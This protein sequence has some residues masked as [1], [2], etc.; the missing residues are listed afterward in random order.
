MV[1]IKKI[2]FLKNTPTNHELHVIIP[3][4]SLGQALPSGILCSHP[5]LPRDHHLSGY[6]NQYNRQ[7]PWFL[8]GL[9]SQMVGSHTQ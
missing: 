7:G 8:S 5:A 2:F 3:L 4:A 9:P 6:L 1:H